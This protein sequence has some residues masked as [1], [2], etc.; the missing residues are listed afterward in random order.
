MIYPLGIAATVAG[1]L[2]IVS[3]VVESRS[4]NSIQRTTQN[5]S[6]K[7][8]MTSKVSDIIEKTNRATP[9]END[10]SAHKQRYHTKNGVEWIDK[11]PY[12]RGGKSDV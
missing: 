3:S 2:K 9:N 5:F 10:V 12:H 11:A 8:D 4:G 1:T 6:G 7:S